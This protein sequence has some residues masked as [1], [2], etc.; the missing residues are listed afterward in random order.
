LIV[1]VVTVTVVV[2]ALR[3][4]DNR[5][6]AVRWMDD[7]AATRWLVRL[8]RRF[9]P[10]LRF[11]WDRVTP[12]GTF[13]LEFTSLMAI[14]AVACFV[15]IA[16]TVIVGE[17]P[18]PTP[19]DMTAAEIVESLRAGWLVHAAKAVTALGSA[20]VI[21]PLALV[22]A[23]LLAAAGRWAEVGV[24]AA[25]LLMVIVGVH[26]IK[27]A[28]DRPR[29]PGGLVDTSGSSFPSAHA[30]YSTFYVLLAV[31]IVVRL[32][33]GMARGALVVF[34]GIGLAALIGLSRVYLEV[35][36]LSDVSAGWALGAA[37]F[38]LW[39]AVALVI[40]TVRHNGLDGRAPP[41]TAED[42]R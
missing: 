27:D 12:G 19:G 30:A 42:R 6:R 34:A 8:A 16:Y 10:Q 28:V 9:G 2:R 38:S 1:L 18:G 13:G 39:A 20:A 4:E 15:L 7:H 40:T 17:D 22:C 25:G 26:E 41:G 3:V 23:V 5:R 37:S 36:Y 35:H 24:L 32:R 21:L 33:P 11:L 31:T 29:P 14:F